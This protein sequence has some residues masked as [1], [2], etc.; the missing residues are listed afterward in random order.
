MI[1]Q[2]TVKPRFTGRE[3]VELWKLLA[4][5]LFDFLD[6]GLRAYSRSGQE[7]VNRDTLPRKRKYSYKEILKQVHLEE[8]DYQTQFVLTKLGSQPPPR[9]KLTEKEIEQKA[10]IRYKS[11]PF[12][13]PIIPKGC[14]AVSF[15]LSTDEK[16]REEQTEEAMS[17]LFKRTD[18]E[19][20]QNEHPEI[21][22]KEAVRLEFVED[23]PIDQRATGQGSPLPDEKATG[24]EIVEDQ[25]GAEQKAREEDSQEM[26][27]LAKEDCSKD[28]EFIEMLKKARAEADFLYDNLLTFKRGR[29]FDKRVLEDRELEA[30]EDALN[31]LK[32]E[33][34]KA[35]IQQKEKFKWVKENYLKN[36]AIYEMGPGKEKRAF[37]GK[38]LQTVVKAYYP[39]N[40]KLWGDYERLYK[41]S[42][43]IKKK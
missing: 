5:Q 11:Q 39:D 16:R 8:G 22:S 32:D 21:F 2:V 3:L 19:D 33:T 24:P 20:F 25:K 1:K 17:F 13:T 6:Q 29:G 9:K 14:I 7:I 37:I 26:P 42:Q 12:D 31:V 40:N 4:S 23:E 38:L 27:E 36:R 28:P 15:T 30:P 35:F 43:E 34:I 18:I 10:R 41:L